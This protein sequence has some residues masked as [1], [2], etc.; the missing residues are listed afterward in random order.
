MPKAGAYNDSMR[1]CDLYSNPYDTRLQARPALVKH[2][3][4]CY[5]KTKDTLESKHSMLEKEIFQRFMNRNFDVSKEKQVFLVRIGK[6]LFL[7]IMVPSYIFCYGIPKW[8][9]T[10]ALPQLYQITSNL[11]KLMSKKLGDVARQGMAA[12]KSLSQRIT[13]PILA[14]IQTRIE[15]TNQLYSR[16]KEKALLLLNTLKYPF[17]QF[18]QKVMSPISNRYRQIAAALQKA[19]AKYTQIKEM[20]SDFKAKVRH[21]L[22]YLPDTIGEKLEQLFDKM[23]NLRASI[24]KAFDPVVAWIE[25]K[26][27]RFS[28]S[29]NRLGNMFIHRPLEA[30]R[31]ALSSVTQPIIGW[32]APKYQAMNHALEK[33]GNKIHNFKEKIKEKIREK[34]KEIWK[35]ITD[36]VDKALES[37]EKAVQ[38]VANHVIQM[39]PQ[40]VISFFIPFVNL[41]RDPYKLFRRRK[42]LKGK[43]KRIRQIAG[44]GANILLRYVSR[45][46]SAFERGYK[47]AKVKLIK[48]PSILLKVLKKVAMFIVTALQ[49]VFH[50]FRLMFAWIRALIRY[51]MYLVREKAKVYFLAKQS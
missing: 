42:P 32:M 51:G 38:A 4:D 49:G 16:I 13:S 5:A 47:R 39:I 12:L 19:Y 10:E 23:A 11:M 18:D 17:Q 1:R 3:A 30:T 41:I 15:Q 21:T 31:R 43:F 22:I 37:A 40:P 29:M 26:Y 36:R 7:A 25:P 20:I 48:V 9:F 34:A 6:Y 8:L 14:F 27:V 33:T 50:L 24:Q 28:E 46:L 35:G 2:R 44:E 45:A